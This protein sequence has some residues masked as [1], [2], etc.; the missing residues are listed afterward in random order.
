MAGAMSRSSKRRRKRRRG[1]K[2]GAVMFALAFLL[3]GFIGAYYITQFPKAVQKVAYPLH[4]EDL[5][6]KYAGEYQLDPARV[7]AV[8]Y[9]ESSFRSAA[10][11]SA[12]ALG[13]MQI[14]PETGQWISE[15]LGED[16]YEVENL[17][18]P[19]T[20]IRYG[21]WYLNYLDNRFDGDLTKATAAYHAGGGK[22]NEWLKDERY[23]ADGDTL[24]DIPFK[25]TNAYVKNV[26]EAYEKYKEII[27][28]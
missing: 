10:V 1:I 21:C 23:S 3:L 22:V 20:N 6:E 26:S 9:C 11:S 17:T 19:D 18:V 8:I 28:S 5:I 14:M 27:D 4:Y 25:Q 12:G 7:A 2:A 13:L 24:T 15:K 16:D